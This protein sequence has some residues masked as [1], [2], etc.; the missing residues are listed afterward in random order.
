MMRMFT[1][2]A[3]G[4]GSA[5]S[6]VGETLFDASLGT[7][8]DQQGWAFVSLPLA[9]TE[10]VADS[11]VQLNTLIASSELSGFSRLAPTPLDRTAGFRVSFTLQLHEE[12]HKN[13][14]RAGLSIVVLGADKHGLELAFWTDR[15]W[16]Q[17]DAPLFTHGEEALFN[18]TASFVNYELAIGA[19]TYTLRAE[20]LELLSGR[21][22]DYTPFV[23]PLDPYETP[24]FL[25][26][27]DDTTSAKASFSLRRVDVLTTEPEPP[28]LSFNPPK[29]GDSSLNLS[30][31]PAH[32]L[33]RATQ[34]NP[35]NWTDFST[36]SPLALPLIG[37]GEFFR[38]VPK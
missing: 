28:H 32:K 22:R 1:A 7:P 38:V 29:A 12:A 8:P 36:D 18:T 3:A 20:G 15:V 23:G 30:W 24:N 2:L 16:A 33:Q 9:L 14:D 27:G 21:V 34:F 10:V 35:V 4:L 31:S 19:N 37:S 6:L 5:L 13:P 26:V 11:A 25:F 17:N